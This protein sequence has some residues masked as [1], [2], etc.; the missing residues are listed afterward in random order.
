MSS[1]LP[2]LEEMRG[3]FCDTQ[4]VIA[5]QKPS[6]TKAFIYNKYCSLVYLIWKKVQIDSITQKDD[7]SVQIYSTDHCNQVTGVL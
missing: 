6:S 1:S 2:Y 3:F 4:E 7:F 5:Q